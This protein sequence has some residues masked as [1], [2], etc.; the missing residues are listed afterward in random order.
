MAAKYCDNCN[1]SRNGNYC[2]VCG[3]ALKEYQ[4]CPECNNQI[5]AFEN[6]CSE[7]GRA[8]DE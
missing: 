4:R 5:W 6:F 3:K 2:G 7:C 8:K 1:T